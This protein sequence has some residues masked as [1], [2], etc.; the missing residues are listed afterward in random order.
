MTSQGAERKVSLQINLLDISL[1]ETFWNSTHQNLD[2]NLNT[3]H[4]LNETVGSPG[5]HYFNESV[6]SPG[7]LSLN[8]SEH[9]F[10]MSLHET[11]TLVFPSYIRIVSTLFCVLVLIIGVFGNVLV[12]V[13]LLKNKDMRNSTNLFLFNLSFADFLVLVVCLPTALLELN[14]PP[15]V[16]LLGRTMCKY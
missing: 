11:S 10:N 12:I 4:Y 6:G 16:W 1:N 3:N 14:S 9:V 7:K 5:N 13:V 15:E 8:L 2:Q